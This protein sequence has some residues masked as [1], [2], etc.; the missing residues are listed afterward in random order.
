MNQEKKTLDISYE[1]Y[2]F[3]LA[4]RL[5]IFRHGWVFRDMITHKDNV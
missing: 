2:A 3:E 1:N 5:N 4:D